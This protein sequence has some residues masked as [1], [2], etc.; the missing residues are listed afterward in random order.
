[1]RT[2]E[3]QSKPS[4][5]KRVVYI[6]EELSGD[7]SQLNTPKQHKKMANDQGNA[8]NK[9]SRIKIIIAR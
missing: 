2:V 9:N 3:N 8:L 7:E 4:R 1:M 5:K 6:Q